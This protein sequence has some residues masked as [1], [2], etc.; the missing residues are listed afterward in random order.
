MAKHSRAC[1]CMCIRSR[2]A[3]RKEVAGTF[4]SFVPSLKVAFVLR[5][6]GIRYGAERQ[7]V[8]WAVGEWK[9]IF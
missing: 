5:E 3:A 4:R 8:K 6:L 1:A 2:I 7:R 9:S